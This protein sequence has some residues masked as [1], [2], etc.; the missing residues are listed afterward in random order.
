MGEETSSQCDPPFVHCFLDGRF[1]CECGAERHDE[2][3]ADMIF[4]LTMMESHGQSPGAARV[5]D[6]AA[7]W[8]SLM[9]AA[10]LVDWSAYRW[11][12][13]EATAYF[14]IPPRQSSRFSRCLV[15]SHW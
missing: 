11:G 4:A 3:L 15:S 8:V 5:V 1:D 9:I 12:S 6:G 13:S 10:S 7:V 14:S 2:V